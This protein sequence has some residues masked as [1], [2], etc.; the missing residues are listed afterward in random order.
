MRKTIN[1]LITLS[2]VVGFIIV[3]GALGHVD[4]LFEIGERVSLSETAITILIGSLFGL[5]AFIRGVVNE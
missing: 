4:Y 1:T 3:I 5:P 2:A